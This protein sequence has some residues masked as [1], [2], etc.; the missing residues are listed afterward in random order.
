MTGVIS[1]QNVTK[2]YGEVL[3]LNGFTVEVP[4]GITALV[5]PNGAGKSTFFRILIG[6][7]RADG[8]ELSVLGRPAWGTATIHRDVGYCPEGPALYDW[9]TGWEFVHYL[10]RIDGY[11]AAEADR[12]T[13]QALRDVGMGAAAQRRMRGYSKGMRQRVKIAQAIAHD[14]KLLLLDE[15]LNG[16]DP[17]GR[18][19]LQALFTH[20]AAA[21]HHVLVSSHVLYELERLTQEVVMI[22]NGR[23]VAEGNL[24][25]LRAALDAHPQS[26]VLRTREPRRLALHLTRWPHVT[27]LEFA[28]EDA[29][30][31]RTRSPDE[32]YQ[33]LPALVTAEH[34]P[35]F[36]MSS[37]D[38]D[39]ETL[40]RYLA[41]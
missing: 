39:L 35:I 4:P 24:H 22:T 25:Q 21:G 23:V 7:L 6:Q 31:V 12:R 16:I 20:L 29:V 5:G 41:A 3:G 34:L 37:P 9:M 26:V 36:E 2:R 14:P 27:T 38:D 10:L 1:A 19:E 13:A 40:F 30:I 33:A 8:G 32:F 11:S 18:V 17:V 28:G 15:P